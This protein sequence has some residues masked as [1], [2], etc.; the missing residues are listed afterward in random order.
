[1]NMTKSQYGGMVDGVELMDVNESIMLPNVNQSMERL[2]RPPRNPMLFY[3]DPD[4][5]QYHT[6]TAED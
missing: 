1:M 4:I 6:F 2:V 5:Y 3:R